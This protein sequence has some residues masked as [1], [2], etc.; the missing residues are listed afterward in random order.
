MAKGKE[1]IWLKIDTNVLLSA[2]LNIYVSKELL[3]IAPGE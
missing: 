2:S 1:K 3:P